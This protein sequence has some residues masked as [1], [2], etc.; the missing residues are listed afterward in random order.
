MLEILG[1]L[2]RKIYVGGPIHLAARDGLFDRCRAV[3]L[4][5]LKRDKMPRSLSANSGNYADYCVYTIR[6]SSLINKFSLLEG[7]HTIDT[8]TK[9]W[10]AAKQIISDALKQGKVVPLLFAAAEETTNVVACAELVSVKT[11]RTNSCSFGKV[12]YLSPMLKKT[13]LRKRDGTR[14]NINFIRDY[15]IRR[16]PPLN[17]AN[18]QGEKKPDLAR[19]PSAKVEAVSRFVAEKKIGGVLKEAAHS[20]SVAHEE[21]PFKWGLRLN[22]KNIML[23]VGTPEVLQVGE[24]W[25]HLLVKD[26]VV[27][28]RLRSDRRLS[29]SDDFPYK[30]A[31]GCITCNM[32]ISAVTLAY[33]ALLP[34]HEAALRVAARS[35][36][37]PSTAK[38]HS[39][40]FIMFLSQ[41]LNCR[42]SQPAYYDASAVYS[43]EELPD[44]RK[45]EEGATT[46]VL[47][48][49]Y[50]RDRAAREQCIRHYG[51]IC[52]A[53]GMSLADRYGSEVSGLIHV[54]HIS[55]LASIKRT[56]EIDPVH[57]LRP[58]CPNCHAV[59]HSVREPRTVDQVKEMIRKKS[60]Q[61]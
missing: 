9:R 32:D 39:P 2:K 55:P 5:S 3:A 52:V 60:S 18:G 42:L 46:Q 6:H 47:I 4:K 45:F 59:I 54:H 34:A 14:I 53:C 36:R 27:P 49:R 48:N 17:F 58:V 23:K 44:D 24:G 33:R 11:G 19:L 61:T 1:C 26:D 29:F 31:P 7:P 56:V 15:A 41:E 40:N 20:I 16:T 13:R 22:Q 57:D 43:P 50:E 51:A 38:D 12:R 25:F 30:N 8:K 10:T 21:E 28:K 37:H 35:P